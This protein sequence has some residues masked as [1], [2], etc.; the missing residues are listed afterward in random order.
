MNI[1]KLIFGCLKR[2]GFQKKKKK[3]KIIIKKLKKKKL[4]NPYTF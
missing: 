4:N 2:S 3:K 1:L